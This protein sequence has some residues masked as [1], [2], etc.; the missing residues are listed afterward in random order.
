MKKNQ[1]IYESIL[2]NESQGIKHAAEN[3]LKELLAPDSQ[4]RSVVI[5]VNTAWTT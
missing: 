2:A 4:G 1:D 5:K 3:L